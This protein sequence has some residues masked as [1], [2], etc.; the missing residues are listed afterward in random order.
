MK[1]HLYNLIVYYRG[2]F[3][4][5]VRSFL[6]FGMLIHHVYKALDYHLYDAEICVQHGSY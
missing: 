5:D 3:D 6:R 4:Y 1:T 2:I